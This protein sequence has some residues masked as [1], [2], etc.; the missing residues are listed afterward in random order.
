MSYSVEAHPWTAGPITAC[1]YGLWFFVTNKSDKYGFYVDKPW[2]IAHSDWIK[3]TIDRECTINVG[4]GR[5]VKTLKDI[6]FASIYNDMA[7][8]IFMCAPDA[9]NDSLT[10]CVNKLHNRGLLI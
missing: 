3:L 1:K 10:A 2:L 8:T 4:A 5:I 9:F 7:N 6:K